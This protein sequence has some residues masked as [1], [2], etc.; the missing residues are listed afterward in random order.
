MQ[1]SFSNLSSLLSR[2][3][4]KLADAVINEINTAIYQAVNGHAE[5]ITADAATLR[6]EVDDAQAARKQARDE[7]RAQKQAQKEAQKA[8]END[9]EPVNESRTIASRYITF[10]MASLLAGTNISSMCNALNSYIHLLLTGQFVRTMV[11]SRVF[12]QF[13]LLSTSSTYIAEGSAITADDIT[14]IA[15]HLPALGECNRAMRR[16]FE[17]LLQKQANRR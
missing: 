9:D 10:D 3:G 7:R 16:K 13:L 8:A 1:H 6:T 14:Y 5:E 12:E 15:N 17:R 4:A 2:C 11:N